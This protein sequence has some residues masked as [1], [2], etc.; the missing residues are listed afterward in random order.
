[1]NLKAASDYVSFYIV[2]RFQ[3]NACLEL[4]LAIC[5]TAFILAFVYKFLYYVLGIGGGSQKDLRH[6]PEV[7]YWWPMAGGRRC[8]IFGWF[9]LHKLMKKYPWA[10]WNVKNYGSL[11]SRCKHMDYVSL[12]SEH[13]DWHKLLKFQ[14]SGF[15]KHKSCSLQLIDCTNKWIKTL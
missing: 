10:Y 3:F 12:L 2:I 1:M 7:A 14:Q 4:V 11:L 13:L 6:P 9:V 5:F 8:K 15:Q